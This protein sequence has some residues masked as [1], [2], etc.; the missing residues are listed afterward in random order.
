MR[1]G[2]PH[3]EQIRESTEERHGPS[4]CLLS[5]FLVYPMYT[6]PL[7]PYK[8]MHLCIRLS[9]PLFSSI[10]S[11]LTA[12]SD[13]FYRQRTHN[14]VG[15]WREPTT[16]D[17]LKP[18]PSKRLLV[19]QRLQFQTWDITLSEQ[20]E[21]IKKA[22]SKGKGNDFINIRIPIQ[23]DSNPLQYFNWLYFYWN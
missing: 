14:Y 18:N 4:L 21:Y 19:N 11:Q 2:W 15:W 9:F 17:E 20:Y 3:D 16:N 22:C 1:G 10:H 5:T 12:G 6:F 8:P 13:V 7:F 23:M